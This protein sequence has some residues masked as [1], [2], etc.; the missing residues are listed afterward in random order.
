[1]SRRPVGNVRRTTNP[2]PSTV[3]VAGT[4]V[5]TE[6]CWVI[7][8]SRPAGQRLFRR[9]HRVD[10]SGERILPRPVPEEVLV[11]VV[12]RV[13]FP[14]KGIDAA[15]EDRGDDATGVVLVPL[16]PGPVARRQRV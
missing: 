5:A 11:H 14:P 15:C 2:P 13:V 4:T 12:H 9:R 3:R 6:R 8:A 7:P 16:L 1:M 10:C